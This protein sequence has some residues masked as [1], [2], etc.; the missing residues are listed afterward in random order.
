[1]SP[2]FWLGITCLGLGIAITSSF[3][4][5]SWKK[6]L[7]LLSAVTICGVGSFFLAAQLQPK[8]LESR[9]KERAYGIY[10][11]VRNYF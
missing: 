8:T 11:S 4:E 1:M 7:L 5:K 3:F 9:V 10:E 2:L 6:T